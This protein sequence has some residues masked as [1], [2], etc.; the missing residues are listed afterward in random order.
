MMTRG[1]CVCLLGYVR[2][3]Y[4]YA[5]INVPGRFLVCMLLRERLAHLPIRR[6]CTQEFDR[7]MIKQLRDFSKKFLSDPLKYTD[8]TGAGD[9]PV[10]IRESYV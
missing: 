2:R 1:S 5:G 4:E 10:V 6:A 8:T 7:E 3:L 9:Q